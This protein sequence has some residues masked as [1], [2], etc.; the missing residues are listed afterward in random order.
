[1]LRIINLEEIQGM[2]LGIPGLV[3]LQEQG[4][5]GFIEGVKQWLAKLE[6]GLEAN[7]MPEAG[8]IAALRAT[9]IS[10]ERGVI[11]AGVEFHGRATGRKI[12]GATAAFVLRQASDLISC[13][14][15]KDSER[16]A[17]AE[18]LARQLVTLAKAKGSIRGLP[19]EGSSTAADKLRAVWRIMSADPML[20]PGTQNV[21]G[22]VGPYDALIILDR[23]IVRDTPENQPY[24]QSPAAGKPSRKSGRHFKS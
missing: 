18:R 17:E 1:M 16:I 3:D 7:R 13:A 6:K 24:I 21:E 20:S 15:Q 11:P 19:G 4:H 23:I 9:L 14:I 5:P 10:A 2:L 22:L 12:R 8:N